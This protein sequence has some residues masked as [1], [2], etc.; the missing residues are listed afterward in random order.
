MRATFGVLTPIT[1]DPYAREELAAL[2]S[3]VG[4]GLIDAVWVRDLPCAPAGDPDSGQGDDPFAHVA[5]LAGRGCLPH[6]VGVASVVMGTRHP[7]VMARAAV[8]AQV[9]TGGGFVLG[10]GS[11]GKP[12]VSAALGISDRSL[13]E[14]RREWFAI[15]RALQ[16]ATPAGSVFPLP[17][18]FQ[19]PPMWLASD[20]M[21]KWA[22]VGETAGGWL[23]FFASP[24]TLLSSYDHVVS[25]RGDGP[26]V[27]V[28]LDLHL[29]P[30]DEEPTTVLP[31]ARGVV[32]CSLRQLRSVL[33]PLPDLPVDHLLL[34]LRTGGA[35]GVRRVRDVWDA[36]AG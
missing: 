7:L 13:D 16:G 23:T 28:R 27:A 33:D 19:P 18:D 11:G 26:T 35:D 25:A 5:F 4:D 24:T 3:L 20:D 14:F 1:R 32:T 2:E 22:V 31:P 21:E 36:A 12:P 17:D 10:L 6:T 8:G 15:E 34:N 9:H 29:V 30:A